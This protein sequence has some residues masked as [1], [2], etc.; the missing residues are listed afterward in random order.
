MIVAHAKD[1]SIGKNGDLPWRLPDDL[2]WFKTK[3][4]NHIIVM[5]RKTWDSLGGKPLPK[6]HHVI[7]TRNKN[8]EVPEGVTVLHDV[9]SV[10]NF[11][12]EQGAFFPDFIDLEWET[13]FRAAHPADERHA[14][15]FV[16]NIL[17]R[18]D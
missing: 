6:R 7:I 13:E 16:F 4:I 15:S 14:Y 17:E 18:K 10:L 9:P 2:R 11:A 1:R 5:G 12:K 3:T 8:L